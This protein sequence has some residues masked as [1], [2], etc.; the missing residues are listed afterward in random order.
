MTPTEYA[1]VHFDTVA[2]HQSN[3]IMNSNDTEFKQGLSGSL[4]GLAHGLNE[5]AVAL[6]ATYILL[7]QVSKK[8][9]NLS[10]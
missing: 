7:E 1:K 9:D 4:G 10:K 6:R 5:M 3:R 8:L 2:N